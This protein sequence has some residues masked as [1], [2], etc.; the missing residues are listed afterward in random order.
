[1]VNFLVSADA[2]AHVALGGD[3]FK[4]VLA[5]CLWDFFRIVQLGE[6]GARWD[7]H[8]SSNNWP[9]PWSTAGLVAT[10]NYESCVE[11]GDVFFG[12]VERQL[13]EE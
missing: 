1:M 7:Y 5:D 8:R 12:V 3:Q 6:A 9:R 4:K 13:V 2:N 11:I 10:G